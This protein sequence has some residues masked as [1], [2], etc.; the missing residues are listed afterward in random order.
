MDATRVTVQCTKDWHGGSGTGK[1]PEDTG[2][3]LC[4]LSSVGDRNVESQSGSKSHR[5]DQTHITGHR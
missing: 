3:R 2:G 4:V 5:N 1:E